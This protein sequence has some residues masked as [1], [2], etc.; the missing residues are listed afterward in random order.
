MTDE[1]SNKDDHYAGLA[2]AGGGPK[3]DYMD[4]GINNS[5]DGY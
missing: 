2:N 3:E 5:H 1:R 4:P